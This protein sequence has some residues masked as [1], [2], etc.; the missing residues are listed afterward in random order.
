MTL[1]CLL[2]VLAGMIVVPILAA[3]AFAV[4]IQP[5]YIADRVFGVHPLWGMVFWLVALGGFVGMNI[6]RDERNAG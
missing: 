5:L 3:I 6:C 4:F 1:K 2:Y